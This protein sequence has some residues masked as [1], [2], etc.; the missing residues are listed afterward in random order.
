LRLPYLLAVVVL[1]TAAAVL[2]VNGIGGDDEDA[3]QDARQ[4]ADTASTAP[5]PRAD[6]TPASC[7]PLTIV[8]AT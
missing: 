7:T 5:A 1:V 6:G 2:L 4:D 8:V 3:R